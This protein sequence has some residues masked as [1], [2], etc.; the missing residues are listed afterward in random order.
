[1]DLSCFINVE[2][3]NNIM[4]MINN[5]V[6]QTMIKTP[7]I[8]IRPRSV[9]DQQSLWPIIFDNSCY[10]NISKWNE[11]SVSTFKLTLKSR[12]QNTQTNGAQNFYDS[13]TD[14]Q[15]PSNEDCD[16]VMIEIR[17][18]M[19]N[20]EESCLLISVPLFHAYI[21]IIRFL[22]FPHHF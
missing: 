4:Y 3:E 2:A 22:E 12:C 6:Q 21:F 20:S 16:A 17:P 11:P 13:M 19:V 5:S 10:V 7:F 1:M 8:A 15:T 9:L 14:K 18:A